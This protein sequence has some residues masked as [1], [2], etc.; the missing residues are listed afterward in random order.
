MRRLASGG[1]FRSNSRMRVGIFKTARRCRFFGT[2]AAMI[3][4]ASLLGAASRA[5]G[6]KQGWFVDSDPRHRAF[7]QYVPAANAPRLLVLGCLRDVDSFVVLAHRQS[8]DAPASGPATLML[9]NG[10][11]KYEIEGKFDANATGIG[12]PGFVGEF[13][14][15]GRAFRELRRKLMPVLKTR[16][17]IT[18]TLGNWSQILPASGLAAALGRFE[19]ICFDEN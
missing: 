3:A 19:A 14:L 7:L 15:G 10:A 9:T 17:S 18:L 8:N 2:A 16:G 5:T 11:A 12:E 4:F 6:A 1:G 13:E